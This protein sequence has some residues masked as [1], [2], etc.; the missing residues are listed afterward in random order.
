MFF[1]VIDR[2]TLYKNTLEF[3]HNLIGFFTGILYSL[4]VLPS[5]MKPVSKR[6]HI[7]S[8]ALKVYEMSLNI[9]RFLCTSVGK[10]FRSAFYATVWLLKFSFH[11][12]Y[13][14]LSWVFYGTKKVIWGMTFSSKVLYIII[15]RLVIIYTC[16]LLAGEIIE[17]LV[18]MGLD[19]LCSQCTRS[20]EKD[21][22]RIGLYFSYWIG[23]F[24]YYIWSMLSGW[25]RSRIKRL[26]PFFIFEIY[27]IFGFF[28]T[29]LFAITL[30]FLIKNINLLYNCY[31]AMHNKI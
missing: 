4:G 26:V 1:A 21:V 31:F 15:P 27:N 3:M 24:C 16:L 30:P 11:N 13:C 17:S 5:S 19:K 8:K 2:H 20:E 14:F 12:L 28:F 22:N 18:D 25:L 9:P 6:S 10:I 29:V 7:S 23:S